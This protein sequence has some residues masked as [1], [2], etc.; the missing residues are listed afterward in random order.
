MT[1]SRPRILIAIGG[2]VTILICPTFMLLFKSN[3]ELMRQMT[4][5][6]DL[7]FGAPAPVGRSSIAQAI[8]AHEP[9]VPTIK[10]EPM[11]QQIEQ[12]Q[13]PNPAM[14]KQETVDNVTRP[15]IGMAACLLNLLLI[16][17]AVR[18]RPHGAAINKRSFRATRSLGHTVLDIM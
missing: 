4:F 7:S 9:G 13:K 2:L 1:R 8:K 10:P 3:Q 14:M 5:N 16:Q 17:F 15:P 11:E 18:C 12:Q 6:K